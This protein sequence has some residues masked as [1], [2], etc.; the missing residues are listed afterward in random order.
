[1]ALLKYQRS[2]TEGIGD[3]ENAEMI[4]DPIKD[5]ADLSDISPVNHADKIAV[6]LL[7]VYSKDDQ[8]V[9]F[10]QARLMTSA[11]DKGNKPY[12]L[13][14]RHNEGHGF[15]TYEHRLEL[16]QEIDKFLAANMTAR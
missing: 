11:L 7:L 3:E 10:E 1:V 15:F 8:T 16:Y 9:P 4:G 14:T 2:V 6:P 13:V 5:A 12:Q